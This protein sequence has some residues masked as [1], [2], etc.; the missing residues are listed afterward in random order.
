MS[1]NEIMAKASRACHTGLL[2]LKKHSPKILVIAGVVGT[3]AGTV[4]AC[5]ATLKAKE[6]VDAHKASVET[7]HEAAANHPEEFTENDKQ[8]ALVETYG[9]TAIK[10]GALYGPA[11]L[12]GAASVTSILVGYNILHKRNV[13]AIAAYTAAATEFKQYRGRVIERF[14][15]ELDRELKYNIR[16]EQVEERTVDENGNESINKTTVTTVNPEYSEFTKC[17]DESCAAFEKSPEDNMKFLKCQQNYANDLLKRRGHLFLNEV[18]DMLGF[19]RTSAGSIVG[20]IYDEDCPN[21]DNYVDF[22]IFNIKS[23]AARNFVNGY[24]RAIWLDFNVDGVIYD[25]I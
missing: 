9:Q 15:K 1:K 22:G 14:G 24:E 8:R 3:V 25:K 19:Q 21:G 12:V 23:E 16:T 10:F 5:K 2:Q 7:I 13:A 4:M 20:W 6:V 18:Y 17:F 11:V